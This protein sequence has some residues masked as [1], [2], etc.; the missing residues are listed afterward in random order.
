MKKKFLIGSAI[1]SAIILCASVCFI[2]NQNDL[3]DLKSDNV[4]ASAQRIDDL[5]KGCSI[6]F[7]EGACWSDGKNGS[8]IGCFHSFIL[9]LD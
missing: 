9:P 8:T 5:S 3:D 1:C 6:C 2:S 4:E 7:G